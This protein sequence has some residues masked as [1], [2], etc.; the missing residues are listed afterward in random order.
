MPDYVIKG[1]VCDN[2]GNKITN[3]KVQAMNS[4]HRLL[5]Y[6][7]DAML[8]SVWVNIDGKFEIPFDKKDFHASFFENNPD[9]Y[10][11]IRNSFGQIIKKTEIRKDVKSSDIKN[12]TFDI[13]LDSTKET[14]TYSENPYSNSIDIVMSS[15]GKLDESVDIHPGDYLRV[16]ELLVSTVSDWALYTT[17]SMWKVI[18]YDGPQV[19]RYPWKQNDRPYKKLWTT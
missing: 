12:L 1:S 8:G 18:G 19:P 17:E 5:Q 11:I 15:F 14:V 16:V 6:Q 13:H 10:L 3:V 9:L 2:Q 4:D 7:N